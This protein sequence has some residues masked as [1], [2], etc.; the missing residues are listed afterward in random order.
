MNMKK[1][2]FL[3]LIFSLFP[4]NILAQTTNE[5][6]VT[7]NAK[8]AIVIENTTGKILYNKN[9]NQI[10]SVAS[11]TKM[12]GLILIFDTIEQQGLKYNEMITVS[13]NAKDMGG[14]QIWLEEGEK[15]SVEDLIK[16][17]TL[18]SANDAM[19][20][21]AERIAGT[22]EAFVKLMNNKAKELNL[23]N[24]H[25]INSTG[26]DEEG[27][28]S[29]AYDMA[30]IAQELLKYE[31]A[32]KY[33]SIYEDYIRKDTENK[34][35]IVNTNKLVRFY[36]GVDGLKTG[37][38]EEAG[39]CMAITIN[40]NNLRVI[41]V[42]LGYNDT[43][44][45]NKE[46]SS[47]LDYIYNQYEARV[48]YKKNDVVTTTKLENANVDEIDLVTKEDILVVTKKTD[49]KEKYQYDIKLNDIKYPIKKGD[50]LGKL[51]ITNNNSKII[52]TDLITNKNINKINILSLYFK[53]L[54]QL[55]TNNY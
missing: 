32:L 53:N 45:R 17:I 31:D 51:T 3:L 16:G 4:F 38:T 23:K 8:S 1:I 21:L 9:A 54:K 35:W 52:T 7:Q 55:L 5:A 27:H 15:I 37:S 42:T 20:A 13:K 14:S 39:K 25:F 43:D 46:T 48:I 44:T 30:K 11:L 50:I 26:L 10:T 2:C 47:L 36:E 12:M 33:T 6:D 34:S 49:P 19:V 22:E 28:Y 18:A 41:A 29:T 24:T 40:K